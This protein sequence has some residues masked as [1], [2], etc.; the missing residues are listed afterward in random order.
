M[1]SPYFDQEETMQRSEH[2]EALQAIQAVVATTTGRHLLKYLFKLFEVG[3]LPDEG[4]SNDLLRSRLGELKVG[5]K[6]YE[7]MSEAEPQQVA[8]ILAQ[9]EREKYVQQV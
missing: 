4:L 1:Q 3:Q 9:I 2:Q 5:R 8:L 6:F 7:L